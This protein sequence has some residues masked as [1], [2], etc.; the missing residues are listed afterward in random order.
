MQEVC[1]VGSV[2]ID[3]KRSI[4]FFAKDFKRSINEMETLEWRRLVEMVSL[5]GHFCSGEREMLRP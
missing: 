4:F 5:P 1:A 2:T 3:F